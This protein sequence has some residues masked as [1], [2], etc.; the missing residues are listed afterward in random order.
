[1]KTMKTTN[2]NAAEEA[3]EHTPKDLIEESPGEIYPSGSLLLRD[4]VGSVG[5]NEGNKY[6]L[7]TLMNRGPLVQSKQTG[8]YFSLSWEDIVR[9]A[10]EAGIDEEEGDEGSDDND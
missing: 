5:D 10:V 2:E 9:L 3:P 8:K 7:C 1:M 4:A 6:E